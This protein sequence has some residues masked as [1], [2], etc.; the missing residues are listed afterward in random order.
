MTEPLFMALD[1]YSMEPEPISTAYFINPSHQSV[2]ICVPLP[3]LGNEPVKRYCGIEYIATK[4][5]SL[6]ASFSIRSM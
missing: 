2:S 4:E 3:L 1:M 5:E 6:K